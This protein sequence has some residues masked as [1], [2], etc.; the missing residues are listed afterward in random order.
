MSNVANPSLRPWQFVQRAN[1]FEGNIV[2]RAKNKPMPLM[3]RC[4][5]WALAV[6]QAFAT[7]ATTFALARKWTTAKVDQR[8]FG[9][10]SC[11]PSIL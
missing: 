11:W 6:G 8:A 9:K 7:A 2:W 1:I 5:W 3:L 4:V 10:K